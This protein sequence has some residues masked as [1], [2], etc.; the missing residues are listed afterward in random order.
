[1]AAKRK[2]SWRRFGLLLAIGAVA[3]G[4]LFFHLTYTATFRFWIPL[5]IGSGP[6]GPAV[7]PAPFAAV[8]TDRPVVLLGLGDSVTAGFGASPGNAYVER[9]VHGSPVEPAGMEGVH[10]SAVMP[11]LRVVNLSVSGSDSLQH[12]SEQVSGLEAFPEETFGAVVM[13]TGGN[14]L[15]HWYGRGEPKEGAMYGASMEQAAPWIA[16]FADRLDRML[17]RIKEAFP[18]GCAIF[19]ANIYDPSD[20]LGDPAAAGLPPWPDF[21]VIHQAYNAV[22]ADA[23]AARSGVHLVDI[24]GPFLGHGVHCT[25]F[26]TPHYRA[27]DPTYWYFDNLEDP[28]DRG[29]DAIRR[30]FLNAMAAELPARLAS[31]R[32]NAD[33]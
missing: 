17:T 16:N 2:S 6:A 30:I 8:W 3:V 21:P 13:T 27:E 31:A 9:L 5:P 33:I 11:N 19:L 7:D 12:E 15:I 22:I 20:G 29:Y 25:Q 10:L 4:G 32:E 28:N 23:A 24:H 14:D 1:M 18:G 26:W